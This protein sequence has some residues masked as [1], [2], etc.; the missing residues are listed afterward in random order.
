M[1]DVNK[2]CSK[3]VMCLTCIQFQSG[4]EADCPDYDITCLFQVEDQDGTLK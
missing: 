4:L 2:Q 3:T 1:Y